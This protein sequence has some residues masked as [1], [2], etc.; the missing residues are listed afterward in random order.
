MIMMIDY[1]D[2]T[3]IFSIANISVIQIDTNK[4]LLYLLM[5]SLIREVTIK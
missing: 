5:L 3:D 4:Y 1:D 2:D